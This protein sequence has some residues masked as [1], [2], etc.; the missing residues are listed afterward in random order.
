MG[1]GSEVVEEKIK[2]S[3]RQIVNRTLAMLTT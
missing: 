1:D 3:K 2:K